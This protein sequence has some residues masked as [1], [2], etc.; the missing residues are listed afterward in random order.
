MKKHQTKNSIEYAD[1]PLLNMLLNHL[2]DSSSDP[3][4]LFVH[5]R[6][7]PLIT[8]DRVVV[9]SFTNNIISHGVI[10]YWQHHHTTLV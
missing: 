4:A 9:D 2:L 1:T 5:L 7:G 6:I 3:A 10:A 8:E